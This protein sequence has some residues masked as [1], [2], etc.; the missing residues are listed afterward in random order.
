MAMLLFAPVFIV[1][2][3]PAVVVDYGRNVKYT[4]AYQAVE[5]DA[6][7]ADSVCHIADSLQNHLAQGWVR[8][9]ELQ[10]RSRESRK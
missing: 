8:L 5:V 3:T 10:N 2:G 7:K 1:S 9:G 4:P 6:A